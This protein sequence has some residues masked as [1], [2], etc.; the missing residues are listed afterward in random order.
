MKRITK[1]LAILLVVCLLTAV[2]A[3]LAEETVTILLP[4]NY[5]CIE[6]DETTSTQEQLDE[7]S[8]N[9]LLYEFT[10]DGQIRCTVTDQEAALQA[11]IQDLEDTFAEAQDQESV[12]YAKS[13]RKLEYNADL[14]EITVICCK[15]DWGF[16]DSFYGM[17][18]M[19]NARDYQLYSGVAENELKCVVRF[20]DE[21]GEEIET[22]D[23]AD[24]LDDEE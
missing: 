7:H 4:I 10:D 1:T 12:L 6:E 5:F 21:N 20:V 14:S 24:Y 22:E 23:L 17:I 3:A 15:D 18:F 9:G 19:T 8:T 13:F 16:L 2:G 11:V